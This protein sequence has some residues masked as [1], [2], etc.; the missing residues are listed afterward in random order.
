VYGAGGF[1]RDASPSDGGGTIDS[2]VFPEVDKI[3]VAVHLDA[4]MSE[5]G[6][7]SEAGI[8][9]LPPPRY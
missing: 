1:F 4:V 9:D 8:V 5:A 3:D 6:G 2:G 7:M